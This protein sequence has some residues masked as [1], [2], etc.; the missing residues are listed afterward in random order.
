MATVGQPT[1]LAAFFVC[2][3]RSVA[4]H[5][6]VKLVLGKYR[7]DEPGLRNIVI[8]AL[9]IKGQECLSFVYRH[10]TKDI[11]K[12]FPVAA[13]LDTVRALLGGDFKS[14]H[15][16]TTTENIQIEFSKKG[17]CMVRR[18][19]ATAAVVPDAEHDREKQRLLDPR[20]PFLQALGVTNAQ[21]QVLPS[22]SRKWKQINVFLDILR[23]AL[24]AS[25]LAAAPRVEVVD[26]GSGK[27]YLTFATH[28]FL[29]NNL[30]REAV[31][32]G[33]EVRAD[34]VRFCN[35]VVGKLGM[36]PLSFREGSVE[37]YAPAAI[38][39]MIALHACDVATD[40][41]IHQGIRAGAAIIMCAPCCHK[42]LRPQLQMPPVLQPLLR[43]GVHLGQEAEM[44]TDTLR[45]LWLEAAGYETQVFEFIALEHT[46]KNK[47]ILAVKRPGA[48][49]REQ[50]LA[51]IKALKDFYGIR[52][53]RLE[54]LLAAD[55]L[56][57]RH[58]TAARSENAPHLADFR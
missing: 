2:L 17:K 33:V 13:G 58:R 56:A 20:R 22:M 11:T 51:Q 12:N 47:M 29:R 15:L 32:T 18:N 44:L 45:A 9:S 38:Q 26:F 24:L 57:A 43:F 48:P 6:L 14:G 25:P 28:D 36:V 5:S 55:G 35:D 10:R 4:E 54:T 23:H 37:S 30:G 19:T 49:R 3:Q 50:A 41:A 7:G 42:E 34:L 21:Y 27:G 46:S 53:H 39:I 31:V 1:E 52:E 16:F 40:L 8:R